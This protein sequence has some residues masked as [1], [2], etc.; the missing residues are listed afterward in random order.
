[1]LTGR[2]SLIWILC[3]LLSLWIVFSLCRTITVQR[4]GWNRMAAKSLSSR[5]IIYPKRGDILAYDGSIL[6]TNLQYYNTY[7]DLRSPSFRIIEFVDSMDLLCDSLASLFPFRNAA[8]WKEHLERGISIPKDRRSRSWSIAKKLTYEQV[9]QVKKLPFFRGYRNSAKSGLVVEPVSVRSYPFGLMAKLSIGHV[10]MTSTDKA[11]IGRSGLECTLDSLLYGVNGVS[12]IA[13][14]ARGT[15]MAVDTPAV[16]GC[17]VTTTI[18]ITIQDILENELGE[19]LLSAKA[20]WGTAMIMEVQ[21]GDIKAISNLERDST[22]ATPRYI[23]AR[24]RIVDRV[25]PGSVMKVMTMAVAMHYG[26]ADPS[27]VY[28]IGRS[29]AYGGKRPIT[30]THSPA[31]LRVDQFI[32]YSS[33]IGMT[34]LTMPQYESNPNLFRDRLR[35]LGFFDRFNSGIAGEVPPYFKTL[36]NNLGGRIDLSRMCYGYTTAI[37]PLYT[38][39]FYNAV[40]NDGKFVRPRLVKSIHYPDGRDSVIPVSYVRDRILS[41]EQAAELR[42]QIHSVVWE[43]GGTA[44]TLRNPIVDIAAK[45]GTAK[46]ALEKPKDSLGHTINVPNWKGG[47]LDGHYR[48]AMCGFFPYDNPRYTCIVVISDPKGMYR[49]ASGSCGIVLKNTALKMYARGM[50]DENRK[51]VPAATEQTQ[52]LAITSFNSSSNNNLRT[53]L[54]LSTLRTFPHPNAEYPAGQVP[55]VR[56][57]SLREALARLES[58]GYAVSFEGLG[59]VDSQTPAPGTAASPGTRVTL[60]LKNLE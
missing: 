53:A 37:P 35:E 12:R 23:E 32:C 6:A 39:A 28:S 2:F 50:L 16:D 48:V 40:A 47:Y 3:V 29:Y 44:K 19:M 25:E 59:Y 46:I 9:Q 10:G 22:S 56:G 17:D 34:K 24:N 26:Y 60:T 4:D 42:R 49:G 38:C 33:N 57:V 7:I 30:D 1:M 51:F 18:D 13:M 14:G 15:Y 58:A 11:V 45:T 20:D 36:Q 5:G 31:Q 8:Q 54:G 43:Q 27:K 52:P 41:T 55:D 21:T